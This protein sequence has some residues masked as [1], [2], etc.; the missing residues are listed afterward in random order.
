M[1]VVDKLVL[2]G[3]MARQLRTMGLLEKIGEEPDDGTAESIVGGPQPAFS[4]GASASERRPR[5]AD[6]EHEVG[7][8]H[9]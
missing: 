7:G 3:A 9:A 1:R 2:R 5:P 6:A 8:R 4:S